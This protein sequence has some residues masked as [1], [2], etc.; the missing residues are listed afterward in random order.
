VTTTLSLSGY[1]EMK[2]KV[3]AGG[4]WRQNIPELQESFESFN[5]TSVASSATGNSISLQDLLVGKTILCSGE[6]K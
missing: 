3:D 6:D 1:A 5:V 2:T 4:I